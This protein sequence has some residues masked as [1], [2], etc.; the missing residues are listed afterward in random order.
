MKEASRPTLKIGDKILFDG[1]RMS[2]TVRAVSADGNYAICTR[3]HNPSRTIRY[4]IIDFCKN[5]RGPDNMIFSDSYLTD[6]DINQR[7]REIEGGVLETSR[8]RSLPL[9]ISKINNLQRDRVV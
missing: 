1:D 5:R 8:R 6:E 7:M 9:K 2:Y 3:P 4:T